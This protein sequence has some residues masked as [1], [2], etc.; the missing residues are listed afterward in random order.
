MREFLFVVGASIALTGC[1]AEK[2]PPSPAASPETPCRI[3]AAAALIGQQSSQELAAEALKRTGARTVRWIWPGTA[4]TMDYQFD[5]LNIEL[6]AAG[7]V[8]R[9]GCG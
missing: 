3:D 1:I 8:T 9:F 7:R 6:D 2:E 4:V 5:R